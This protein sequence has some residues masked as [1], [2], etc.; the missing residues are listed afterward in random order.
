MS[1]IEDALNKAKQLQIT[2]DSSH[3]A[4]TELAEIDHDTHLKR[5]SSSSKQIALM[6]DDGYLSNEELDELNIINPETRNLKAVNRYRELRTNLISKSKGNNFVVM[7]TGCSSEYDSGSTVLNLASAFAFDDSKTSLVIDC[8]LSNPTIDKLLGKEV[9]TGLTD[10]FENEDV[11]TKSIIYSSGIKRSRF[12]P[13]GKKNEVGSEYFISKK[14]RSL[15]RELLNR[16]TDRY[17]FIN[18]ANIVDYADTKI[19][20]DLCDYVILDVR[21]GKVTR[22]EVMEAADA[23]GKDKLLGVIFTGKPT[24]LK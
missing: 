16:Y 18:T 15:M 23:I 19:L 10:F 12:I 24:I 13:A 1:K 7:I 21:Y 6:D 2:V 17:V 3:R 4:G 11:T 5:R 8:N 9:T 14:M 20:V 22:K